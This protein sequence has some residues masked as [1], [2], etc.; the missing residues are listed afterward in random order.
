MRLINL[1]DNGGLLL[2]LILKSN[3]PSAQIT[4]TFF[5]EKRKVIG[6]KERR[7]LSQVVF[8]TLRNHTLISNFLTDAVIPQCVRHP[9]IFKNSIEHSLYLISY[10]LLSDNFPQ[11]FNQIDYSNFLY[12]ESG[13]TLSLL[14]S[15][16]VD[17]TAV[18]SDNTDCIS[19]LEKFNT[20]VKEH[21][22]S[23][24]GKNYANF[25]SNE[26]KLNFLS[27]RYSFPREFM[28]VIA[29]EKMLLSGELSELLAYMNRSANTCIRANVPR[30]SLVEEL[31]E[32]KINCKK[33][34]VSPA[35]VVVEGRHQLTQ[36]NAYKQ[37]KFV[38]QEEASQIVA[39]A[40]NP[41]ENDTILDAC[42]G[43]GGK[44]LHLAYLQNDNGYILACDTEFMKVKEIPKRATLMGLRSLRT[45][46]VDRHCIPN[47]H[48]K[49]LI[50]KM[51][52]DVVVVDA[53]CSGTGTIRREPR[54]KYSINQKLISKISA[55]QMEIIT[56]YSKYVKD[57][58]TLVY[59]T[60]SICPQ[61]NEKIIEYFLSTNPQFQPV[62]LLSDFIEQGVNISDLSDDAYHITLY[63]H[64]H[65]TDGFFISKFRKC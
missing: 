59:S 23:V 4:E 38:I 21:F 22:T 62:P 30:D 51:L 11:Q 17:I 34:D 53:P 16:A 49:K 7:F 3:L 5:R 41:K 13:I 33:G 19:L 58:G 42:A 15:I 37:G 2:K 18:T 8:D 47:A 50:P 57:G 25:L 28:D 20:N 64:I 12:K 10:I 14:Q 52:F 43:A 45:G 36:L 24:V 63:P 1:I 65:K 35:C 6:S 60:C 54:K 39:F 55:M 26:D 31:L 46:V 61:E 48:T 56:E 44:S 32:N 29:D 40:A 27:L 9:N